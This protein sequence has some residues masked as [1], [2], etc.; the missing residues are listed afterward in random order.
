MSDLKQK[1]KNIAANSI[2]GELRGISF[3]TESARE[4]WINEVNKVMDNGMLAIVIAIPLGL[5]SR[6]P[7]RA[8]DSLNEFLENSLK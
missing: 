6:E 4:N 8:Q 5:N 1:I 7:S 2:I 3:S